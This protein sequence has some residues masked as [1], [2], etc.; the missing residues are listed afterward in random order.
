M[1]DILQTTC[2]VLSLGIM[3]NAAIAQDLKTITVALGCFWCVKSDVDTIPGVVE[4][5][6]GYTGGTAR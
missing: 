2:S 3:A 4:T 6:S 5:A 1:V